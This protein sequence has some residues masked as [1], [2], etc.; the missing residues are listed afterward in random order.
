MENLSKVIQY[1]P[2]NILA[3]FTGRI[4]LRKRRILKTYIITKIN[5]LIIK[6]N[7]IEI[8]IHYPVSN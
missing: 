7:N 2:N 3:L 4:V 5:Y 8:K 6:H 1:H